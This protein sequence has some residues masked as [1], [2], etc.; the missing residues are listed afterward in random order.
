[1]LGT[2]VLVCPDFCAAFLALS[3]P[4]S[5]TVPFLSLLLG[6]EDSLSTLVIIPT[7]AVNGLQG[8]VE[9]NVHLCK[10]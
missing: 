6:E 8:L 4:L 3:L 10:D 5:H 2:S 9:A 1:M 7:G